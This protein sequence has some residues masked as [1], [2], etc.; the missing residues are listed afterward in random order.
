[1]LCEFLIWL[2]TARWLRAHPFRE[3]LNTY[4]HR[5]ARVDGKRSLYFGNHAARSTFK[6][7]QAEPISDHDCPT[8]LKLLVKCYCF[9]YMIFLYANQIIMI[10]LLSAILSFCWCCC[11]CCLVTKS[12]WTLC[13]PMDCSPPGSSVHGIFQARILEWLPFPSPEDLPWPRDR[14]QVSCLAG[15]LFITEPLRKATL[16]LSWCFPAFVG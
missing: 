8:V 2:C 16:F 5:V 10:F 11:C 13:N 1:M 9:F 14:T 6:S 3:S 15:R 4:L 7:I 12:S